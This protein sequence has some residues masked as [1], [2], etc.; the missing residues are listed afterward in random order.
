MMSSCGNVF[1]LF[2]TYLSA[3][4]FRTLIERKERKLIEIEIG[5]S[6]LGI[7]VEFSKWGA[8]VVF[9]FDA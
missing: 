1:V 4:V 2:A 9:H 6:F 5:L 8:D 3:R 7:A